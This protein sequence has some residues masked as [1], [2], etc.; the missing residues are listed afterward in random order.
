[1]FLTSGESYTEDGIQPYQ[2]DR[3]YTFILHRMEKDFPDD[4]SL[5]ADLDSASFTVTMPVAEEISQQIAERFKAMKIPAT[6][7]HEKQCSSMTIKIDK[8][9]IY[10]YIINKQPVAFIRS[11]IF[12]GTGVIAY[13]SVSEAYRGRGIGEALVK[14]SVTEMKKSGM[15]NIT[16]STGDLNE[17]AKRLY[18][19]SGFVAIRSNDNKGQPIY[20]YIG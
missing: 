13:L 6:A 10:T 3:D 15:K 20:M 8:Q 7:I 14:H 1:M 4:A 9:L 2:R 18:Q 19:K 12:G 5:Y 17:A 16:L 11:F